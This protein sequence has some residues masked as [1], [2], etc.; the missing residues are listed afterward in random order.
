M[1]RAQIIATAN[2]FFSIIEM[3]RAGSGE[4]ILDDGITDA[5]F[6]NHT[7]ISVLTAH[8]KL[9]KKKDLGPK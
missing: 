3:A 5:I 8:V 1:F 9:K 6:L 4:N 2:I 7:T